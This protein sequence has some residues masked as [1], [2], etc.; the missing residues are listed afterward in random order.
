MRKQ[1]NYCIFAASKQQNATKPTRMMRK[2]ILFLLLLA[3]VIAAARMPKKKPVVERWPD[4]TAMDAWFKDTTKVDI[5]TLGRQY[6]ITD[7]GVKNDS[8][9]IQ[10]QRLQQLIDRIAQEG[11]GVMV[12]PEGTFLT[13]ALFFRQGTHL[14]VKGR[15][16]GSDRI[17]DFPILQTR[18]EGETCHYFSA[19]I[20]ADG[21]D[22]FTISGTGTIDG[23]GL[24]S[25]SSD[26]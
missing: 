8:T 4:G 21:I 7:Y 25:R 23:N 24:L 15:L 1:R 9:V 3:T 26:G 18:I 17:G 13:G 20:N 14:H 2:G 6:V 19:L 11:G 16:K 12:I 5:L 10:T 22:G